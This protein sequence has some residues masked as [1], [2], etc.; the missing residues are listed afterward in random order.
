[1][2]LFGAGLLAALSL[3]WAA[4]SDTVEDELD[5]AL[6]LQAVCVDGSTVEA[7]RTEVG[8]PSG[9][10]RS[11]DSDETP[12]FRDVSSQA[13]VDFLHHH[14]SAP[15]GGGVVVFDFNGDGLHDIYVADSKG[16]NALYRNNGDSTFSDVA[17]AA[18]IDDPKGVGNGGCAAD[19]DNDG[20]QDLF[21][22]NY[23]PNRFFLNK[24]DGT[25][26][27]LTTHAGVQD[28]YS[29][30]R[31]MG[32]AWG[33][34]DADGFLD[35]I[36]VRHLERWNA[37]LV[38]TRDFLPR[39]GAMAL[40]HNDGGGGFVDVT[41]LL[42]DTSHP[43][44]RTKDRYFGNV[45]GAGFQPAWVDYDND[46]DLDLYVVNDF[47]SDIQPNVL[48]RN[49]GPTADGG[50]GFRDVSDISDA[51]VGI[52]GMGLA[53]GDYDLDGHSDFFI[54]NINDNVLLKNN[55]QGRSFVDTSIEMGVRESRKRVGWATAFLDYD[56]DGDEDLY[57]V[58]GYIGDGT[59]LV[60]LED[61]ANLL[62]R[63]GDSGTFTNV[64]SES[65]VDDPGDG[66][67]GAYLDFNRDGCLDLYV[68]NVGG[69]AK[70]FEN[71]CDWGGNWLIV[72]T[73]GTVSNRDGIG[74][75]ISVVAGRSSQVRDV[76]G[77]S[78]SVSQNM[79]EAHF[80]LGRAAM[81][82]SVTIRWPSGAVQTLTD[83]PPNQWL[84][85]TEPR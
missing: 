73:V 57:V 63:N 40:Y 31:S 17:R 8:E 24:G 19:Y 70:L 71:T 20:D 5:D 65:G 6:C 74:A 27:D 82:D 43:R 45:W 51:N 83:V 49:D 52:Y 10:A 41:D 44:T 9:A 54:T 4:G 61:Q 21:L 79:V 26:V 46:G 55:G 66:R 42:G 39:V 75:R 14:F 33:D 15:L 38:I 2:V 29:L 12:M 85:V 32:C 58:N 76:Y 50:W 56:N 28:T 13:G 7:D 3:N 67:G 34:Y 22:T 62:W 47:G 53:I 78:S 23:G 59:K 35:L 25:F 48:W 72:K 18:G 37:M 68:A 81:V 69:R 1:M 80:G 36:V 77:G 64:S 84:T 30:Y 16:P 11:V 60:H